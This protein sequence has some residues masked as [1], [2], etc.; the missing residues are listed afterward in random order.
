[1]LSLTLKLRTDDPSWFYPA[2]TD[3]PAPCSLHYE[4]AR[5]QSRLIPILQRTL[6]EKM[7]GKEKAG[8]KNHTSGNSNW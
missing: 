3:T 2:F 8:K 1:M 7:G 4:A 5:W 6:E